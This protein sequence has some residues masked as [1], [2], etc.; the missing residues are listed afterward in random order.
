MNQV[1][2]VAAYG[3]HWEQA[4]QLWVVA[5]PY[6]RFRKLPYQLLPDGTFRPV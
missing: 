2:D 3:G 6:Q 4:P 5:V 1:I